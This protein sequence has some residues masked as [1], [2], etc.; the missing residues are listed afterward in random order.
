[1]VQPIIVGVAGGSGSGKTTV[2]REIVRGL[3]ATRSP[4]STTTPATATTAT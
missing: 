2:V 1:M 3:G 4:S